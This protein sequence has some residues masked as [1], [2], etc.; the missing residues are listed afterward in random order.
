MDE[1]FITHKL[2]AWEIDLSL[3][4]TFFPEG[5][6]SQIPLVSKKSAQSWLLNEAGLMLSS[7]GYP[8]E[9]EELLIKKTNM[10]IEDKDWKNAS[11]GYR[12]LADLQFRTGELK[13]GRESAQKAVDASEKAKS[14]GGIWVSKAYLAWVLHLLGKGEEAE[15]EFRQADELV[16]KTSGYRLYGFSG[17]N[18]AD[19]LISINK[20]YDAFE[21]VKQNLEICESQNWTNSILRCYRCLGAIERVNGNHEEA[22]DHLQKA[23]EIARKVGVPDIEIEAMLEFGRLH[24]DLGRYEDAIRDANEVLKICARTG[25]K[26]YEPEA[27]VVLSKACMAL[28]DFEQAKNFA[29]S[30]Y[31]KAIG[32]KYRWQGGDA[33]HLLG[34]IYLKMR[35]KESAGEW[36]KKAVACRKE[37]LD[38]EVKDSERMLKSL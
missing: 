29:H 13:S 24:I 15:K 6:L 32:M 1:H 22:E 12:N 25:F 27:E 7:I 33:A 23:L 26:L 4:K 10:Q 36:L 16:K 19:L 5:D 8:N 17:N 9:A 21:L 18:Y 11:V 31:E 38:P 37:I 28:T 3:A 34:E 35:D 30:A 2:G 14:D 20:I